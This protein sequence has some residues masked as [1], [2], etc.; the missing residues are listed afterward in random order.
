MI[1]IHRRKS[2][3]CV[4]E[5]PLRAHDALVH[6]SSQHGYDACMKASH[7]VWFQ[8]K[9]ASSAAKQQ[10]VPPVQAVE[11]TTRTTNDRFGR[12]AAVA[13]GWLGSKWAF[14]GAILVI[15]VWAARGAGVSLF[16]HLATGH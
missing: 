12:F 8:N 13:S 6:H 3:G 2:A 10:A 1:G 11:T 5:E 15:V 14:C 9:T 7:A 4:I 16:G